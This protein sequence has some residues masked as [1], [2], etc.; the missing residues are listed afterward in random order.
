M[1]TPSHCASLL[2]PALSGPSR[3]VPRIHSRC[4]RVHLLVLM[5]LLAGCDSGPESPTAARTDTGSDIVAEQQAKEREAEQ[6][7]IREAEELD[8]LIAAMQPVYDQ[9]DTERK[10]ITK[11]HERLTRR[12]GRQDMPKDHAAEIVEIMSDVNYLL[13]SPKQLGAF[14]SVAGVQAELEAVNLAGERLDLVNTWVPEQR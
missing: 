11:L 7:R 10:R 4:Y 6:L 12:L 9:L 2:A 8:R 3:E 5:T 13:R 14:K 1:S